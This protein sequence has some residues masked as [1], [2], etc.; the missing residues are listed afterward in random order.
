[1]LG[2][3]MQPQNSPY[4]YLHRIFFSQKKKKSNSTA[5]KEGK[6]GRSISID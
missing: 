2:L 1:M 6:K 3:G 4:M 5:T